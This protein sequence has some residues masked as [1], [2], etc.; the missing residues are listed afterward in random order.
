VHMTNN[1]EAVPEPFRKQTK[2][3]KSL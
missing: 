2:P 1:A 3:S